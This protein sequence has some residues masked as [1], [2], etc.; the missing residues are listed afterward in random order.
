[1]FSVLGVAVTAAY[2]VV[3]AFDQALAPLAGGLAAAAAIVMFTVAVRLLLLPLSYYAIR[4]QAS[5]A[6][7]APQVQA[8][9]QRHA[10]HPDRLQRELAALYQREGSGMLAGCLPLLLQLPFL[11]VMYTLF[12]SAT[13][14]GR[15][16]SLLRHD[17]FGAALGS[18]WLSGPGPLSAQGA[19]FF[20]L[21]ALLAA[22]GWLAA[23]VTRALAA[24]QPA[25]T[26]APGQPGQPVPP[27][28][29][30][31]L[32]G[33]VA[34]VLPFTTVAVAAVMPLAA[35]LYL[36]TTTAWAAP[37]RMVLGRRLARAQPVVAAPA[38]PGRG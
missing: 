8:L 15:P 16:N 33:W 34:R 1:M 37:E 20:G 17:L 29:A 36:L 10:G 38:R 30:G 23:R 11:S 22:A 31:G 7:L 12:R 2:H 28:Q 35:G 26:L 14:G 4:G 21:F 19:V 32:M 27:G 25:A 3:S 13:V 18:H 9:R 5:Q 6:R 24:R